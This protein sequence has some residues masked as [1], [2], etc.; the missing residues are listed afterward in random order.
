MSVELIQERERIMAE[1]IQNN[2]D[3]VEF[4]IE[5]YRKL[6]SV[7]DRE[8]RAKLIFICQ[9]PYKQRKAITLL[10]NAG[11]SAKEATEILNINDIRQFD[12]LRAK[13]LRRVLNI[14]NSPK[15]NKF[16]SSFLPVVKKK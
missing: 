1:E 8:D 16:Y 2:G 5:E 9:L 14:L 3:G 11:Y 7:L 10:D 15:H 13:A 6:W 12:R 4:S